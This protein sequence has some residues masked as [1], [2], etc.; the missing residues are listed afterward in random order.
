M[1]ASI[2]RL[3]GFKDV[4]G[5]ESLLVAQIEKAARETF[6]L[7]DFEEIRIPVLEEKVLFTRALGSETDVVQKEMYEFQDRSDVWVAMRPE[8][9]AGVVRA[10]LENKIDKVNGQAKY[11]YVGPMFRSERPQAGRLR[12]FHQIGV[13]QLGFSSPQSDAETILCLTTFLT[14]LGIRGFRVK[15]NNLGTTEDRNVLRERLNASFKNCLGEFCIDC[16]KRYEKNVFRLL[17]CKVPECR[18]AVRSTEWIKAGEPLLGPQVSK[19]SF[20]HFAAV[21]DSL[22]SVNCEFEIDPFMVRGLDYYTKTVFEVTHPGLGSQ[23][24]L[25][26]GGRYDNLIETFG[27]Q[28]AGAVGFAIGI[29]RLILSTP[30]TRDAKTQPIFIAALGEDAFRLGFVVLNALRR[31]GIPSVM[32]TRVRS[33]KSQLRVA[34]KRGAR[35]VVLLGEDEIARKVFILKD[36]QAAAD[37]ERQIEYNL[38]GLMDRFLELY[39]TE[40]VPDLSRPDFHA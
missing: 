3:R 19:D 11:F 23:D 30:F 35:Y 39:R 26:A 40:Y 25:A 5:D 17:D 20:D 2:Q 33:L 27:G 1:S 7:F 15:L 24:A 29:E 16:K 36:M 38:D 9:T 18:K 22:R 21:C 4:Y 34:E 37:A 28:A 14:K 32:E 10:Y 12:Q 6:R 8:G 13:E 31:L